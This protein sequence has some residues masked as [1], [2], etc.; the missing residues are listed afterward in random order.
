MN[1][2]TITV[3]DD[4]NGGFALD[5]KAPAA[6]MVMALARTIAGVEEAF[7]KIVG[8]VRDNHG[9]AQAAAMFNDFA[10]RL[11]EYRERERAGKATTLVT[12]RAPGG[13]Q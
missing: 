1:L 11:R 4:I 3:S 9:Q 12:S 13:G 8:H 6:L 2:L 7:I 10:E 5:S